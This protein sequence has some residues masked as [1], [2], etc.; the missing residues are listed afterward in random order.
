[1]LDTLIGLLPALGSLLKDTTRRRKLQNDRGQR[2][3]ECILRAVNETKLY[4]AALSRGNE[5]DGA[6]EEELSRRWTDTAAALHGID[7]DLAQRCRMKGEYWADPDRWSEQ[8]LRKAKILL[9]EVAADADVLLGWSD[10]QVGR[11]D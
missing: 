9:A 10:P 11:A 4:V 5:R 2:V 7:D 1:M 6:R 8:S 3:V